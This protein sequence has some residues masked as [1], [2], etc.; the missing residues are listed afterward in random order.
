MR[1]F[2][3][4]N[5]IEYNEHWMNAKYITLLLTVLANVPFRKA[6]YRYTKY[7]K[8][9]ILIIQHTEIIIQGIDF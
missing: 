8:F 4:N 5:E 1:Q 3:W 9:K 2:Y 7:T 6:F